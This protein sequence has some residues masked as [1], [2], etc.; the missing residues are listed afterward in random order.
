MTVQ[1]SCVDL[2]GIEKNIDVSNQAVSF[3]LRWEGQAAQYENIEAATN[4]NGIASFV[5]RVDNEVT[6]AERSF[7]DMD[8]YDPDKRFQTP[9]DER[10]R[11]PVL[12]NAGR[13]LIETGD[14]KP[15]VS[16][17]ESK[18]SP[19]PGKLKYALIG[20]GVRV[21]IVA[22]GAA[23]AA[24]VVG[25]GVGSAAGTAGAGTVGSG[26][27]GVGVSGAVA[28]GSLLLPLAGLVATIGITWGLYKAVERQD[29]INESINTHRNKSAKSIHQAEVTISNSS[30]ADDELERETIR[31]G[32]IGNEETCD[33]EETLTI[34]NKVCTYICFIKVGPIYV[35]TIPPFDIRKC[36]KSIQHKN[37]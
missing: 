4:A 36:P 35:E 11:S 27:A 8:R 14:A 34:I 1:L 9:P 33:L 20:T 19:G 25:A 13:N 17:K 2:N 28:G 3:D 15:A 29:K 24:V 26:T 30:D 7:E 21:R 18:P 31:H 22:R 16:E 10:D 37:P 12:Q 6:R 5:F 23:R 32:N